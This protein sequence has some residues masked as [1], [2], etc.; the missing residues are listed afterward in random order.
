MNQV[1]PAVQEA[2]TTFG[3]VKIQ[4]YINIYNTRISDSLA[5]ILLAKGGINACFLFAQIHA[6]LMG[7]FGFIADN[8]YNLAMDMFLVPLLLHI[9]GNPSNGQ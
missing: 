1:T 8:Y 6:D 3:K 2:L 4:L 7:A 9:A 5:I